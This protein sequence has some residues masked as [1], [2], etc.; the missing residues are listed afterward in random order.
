MHSD[1]GTFG[2]CLDIANTSFNMEV[3]AI[4]HLLC[5]EHSMPMQRESCGNFFVE[6]H[7]ILSGTT[8]SGPSVEGT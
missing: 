1:N 6:S 4:G 3:I 2:F 8:E 5:I 7:M